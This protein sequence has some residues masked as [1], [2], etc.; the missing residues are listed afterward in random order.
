MGLKDD[1]L[2]M[3]KEVKEVREHS[4][5]WEMLKDSNKTKRNICFAWT[6][7]LVTIL[8]FWFA[9]IIYLIYVLNDTNTITETVTQE[10]ASGYNNYIGNDGDIFNGDAN[11]NKNN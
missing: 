1:V 8:T 2:E 10:S 7:V 5:A 4:M 6:I 9:T 3:Q 11:N